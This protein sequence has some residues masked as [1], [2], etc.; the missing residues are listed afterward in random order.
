MILDKNNVAAILPQ[1]TPFVMVDKL[2][3]AD[4]IKTVTNF[5]VAKENILVENGR[6]TPA[7]LIEN[8]AQT[9][10]I[11]SAYNAK[12]KEEKPAIGFIVEV[13]NLVIN[14]MPKVDTTITTTVLVEN[15]IFDF[16]I[17]KGS[18]SQNDSELATCVM[19]IFIK[20]N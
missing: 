13:K 11:G 3:W 4:D 19:K 16:V 1:K 18:V 12:I 10:A 6:F 9:V 2:L 17:V 14:Q 5:L 20:P 15:K 8:V 7:G